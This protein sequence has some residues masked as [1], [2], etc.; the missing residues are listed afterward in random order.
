M[1]AAE[2][3]AQRKKQKRLFLSFIFFAVQKS[4]C[5]RDEV[6]EIFLAFFG[7]KINGFGNK[8]HIRLAI[9]RTRFTECIVYMP[10]RWE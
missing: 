6:G 3:I 10:A 1:T 2:T 8:T 7:M 5:C 4:G 9:H